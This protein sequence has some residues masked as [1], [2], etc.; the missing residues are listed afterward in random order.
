MEIFVG[1][2]ETDG[3]TRDF[4]GS[5]RFSAFGIIKEDVNMKKINNRKIMSVNEDMLNCAFTLL[6][7]LIPKA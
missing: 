7:F 4:P 6:F 5:F 1:F 2:W 3:G